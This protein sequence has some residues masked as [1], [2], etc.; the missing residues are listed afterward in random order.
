[1]TEV[2]QRLCRFPGCGRPAMPGEGTGR[3]PLYCDNP[4]HNRAA[5]WRARQQAGV[6]SAPVPAAGEGR[7]VDAARVR[8]GAI[9]AQ[10][11]GMVELL[12]ERLVTLIGELRTLGD[13]EAVEAQLD[14]VRSQAEAEAAAAKAE[15]ARA[16]Q[17]RLVA[18]EERAEAD[19]AA[20]EAL[21]AAEQAEQRLA[22]AQADLDRVRTELEQ[23]VALLLAEQTRLIE[24]HAT[25][26]ERLLADAAAQL[27][28]EHDAR[29]AAEEREAT[30]RQR[31]DH[32]AGRAERAETQASDLRGRLAHAETQILEQAALLAD[33]HRQLAVVTVERDTNV[34]AVEQERATADRRVADLQTAHDRQLARLDTDLA[35]LRQH[36]AE[37]RSRADRAEAVLEHHTGEPDRSDQ[38]A[39]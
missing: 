32:E 30:A 34:R 17:A 38:S 25:D 11:R 3:P 36:L 1:M 27:G 12:D 18:E 9:T 7:P 10:V 35:T 28:A 33:V 39:S 22:Q 14:T 26:R 5:A 21:Q 15:A 20:A 8:A 13:P 16:G 37:Q 6:T 24:D 19:A 4:D 31:A 2:V 23:Q 29:I